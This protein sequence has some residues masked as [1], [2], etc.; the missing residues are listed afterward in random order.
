MLLNSVAD[1]H[2]LSLVEKARDDNGKV[3]CGYTA[4]KALHDWYLCQEQQDSMI[5]HWEKK[6][7]KLQLDQDTSATA[8]I[9]SFEMYVRTLTELG[10]IGLMRRRS[11][12]LS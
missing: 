3:E 1:G 6:L 12:N 2:A 5:A 11:E 9:N 7:P 10:K 8:Y 4:W